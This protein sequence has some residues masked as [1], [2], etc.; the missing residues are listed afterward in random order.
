MPKVKY[1]LVDVYSNNLPVREFTRIKPAV[2]AYRAKVRRF[3][4]IASPLA[5]FPYDLLM[6]KEN[7]DMVKISV[8]PYGGDDDYRIEDTIMGS[9]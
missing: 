6:R 8:F 1:F 9:A 5:V 4:K 3:N 2:R 7:G